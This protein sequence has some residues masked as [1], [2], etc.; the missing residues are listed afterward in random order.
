M[1]YRYIILSSCS[2]LCLHYR[3]SLKENLMVARRM[4]MLVSLSNYSSSITLLPDCCLCICVLLLMRS[5]QAAEAGGRP[6]VCS[7][8]WCSGFLCLYGTLNSCRPLE[9][10]WWLELLLIPQCVVRN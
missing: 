3:H 7:H 4:G 5:L 2:Y 6:A 10:R 1:A 8:S 9:L